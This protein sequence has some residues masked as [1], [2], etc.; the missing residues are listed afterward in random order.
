MSEHT[1]NTDRVIMQATDVS[2]VCIQAL[3]SCRCIG[4]FLHDRETAVYI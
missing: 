4:K 2:I 3:Y 1:A